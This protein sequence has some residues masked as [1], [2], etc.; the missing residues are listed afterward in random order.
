IKEEYEKSYE[1]LSSCGFEDIQRM[2]HELARLF[3][4]NSI[5]EM[6]IKNN[7]NKDTPEYIDHWNLRTNI[8]TTFHTYSNVVKEKEPVYNY[9]NYMM[10]S[11]YKDK[12][13]KI[14]KKDFKYDGKHIKEYIDM[15]KMEE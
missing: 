2:Q 10:N 3:Y 7:P 5:L 15:M 11:E 6:Q 9:M 14:N 1:L 8:I 13:V 12:V 4:L